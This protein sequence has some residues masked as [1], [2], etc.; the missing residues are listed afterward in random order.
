M[1]LNTFL[2]QVRIP[3]KNTKVHKT[4]CSFTFDTAE[5]NDGL[6]LDLKNY[7]S[8]NKEYALLNYKKNGQRVYLHM[9]KI[10][11]PKQSMEVDKDTA[12]PPKK[13]P[14][15]LGI[16]VPG[17]FETEGKVEYDVQETNTIV[18]LPE[19]HTLPLDDPNVPMKIQEAVAAA[20]TA[21]APATVEA[22]LQ[23][24]EKPKPS[25]YAKD[26]L[27]LNNGI[28]TPPSGWKCAKCDLT[29]N[30][31]LNLTD[32]AI[33][34][35]RYN[36]GSGKPGNGHA[37]E[38]YKENGYPL[39]VKLGTITPDGN[40]DVYSYAPDEDD[41]V[42]DPQLAQHLKHFGINISTLEKT[43]K[44]TGE[45]NLDL[46]MNYEWSRLQENDKELT[47]LFGPGYTG[48]ENIG[49]S[50]YL[51]SVMQSLFT[52]PE[53]AQR[54]FDASRAI[55]ERSSGDPNADFYVQMAKLADG[56]LSGRYAVPS[57]DEKDER[58]NPIQDGI[59][60]RS[61]KSLIGKGHA[62][63]S[64]ARQQDAL[65]YL[66]YLLQLI[67]REEKKKGEKDSLPSIFTLEFEERVQCSQS[68]AV[69]YTNRKDN[70]LSLPIPTEKASNMEEVK[71][72]KEKLE[73]LSDDEK[74][75]E[76]VVRAKVSFSDCL[77]S[78]TETETV[79]DFYSSAINAKTTA[80][81]TTKISKF[82]KYLIV[83]MRRFYVDTDWSVKKLDTLVDVPETID[84]EPYRAHGPQ[85]NE[86]L[87][88]ESS[89]DAPAAPA[90]QA[91]ESIVAQL[92]SLGFQKNSI[93]RAV[94]HT[95]NAGVEQATDWLI[96]HMEDMDF[97]EPLVISAPQKNQ[98]P[99]MDEEKV[100]ML[101]SMGFD[102]GQS[103]KALTATDNN[104]ERATEWIFSHMDDMNE[105][106][107]AAV[108]DEGRVEDGPAKY[109]LVSI[110]S[111]MGTSTASGHYVAHIKK[112]G[113]WALF[114]D[115]KV[116]ESADP[117]RDMGYIYLFQRQ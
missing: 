66:Q 10:K 5:S 87:L 23:W 95:K 100:A 74:R 108:Q 13:K 114:N 44:T 48:M 106:P 109:Q 28:K 2:D 34:C 90:F 35:G 53:F 112:K 31:W 72:F 101:M 107:A 80:F 73:K 6:Y 71:Q 39:A 110:I 40:G 22:A 111:H 30:L 8:F 67:E 59:A 12:E 24:E 104:I 62:E 14:T 102:R 82:P 68:N 29:E 94:Y 76:P 55:F 98:G 56:L 96:S 84:L 15:V 69:R 97:N 113:R 79:D 52:V 86:Q 47:R 18:I 64:T 63:F 25:K 46:N 75:K 57:S 21:E 37:L 38:H 42:E 54:Y 16:G 33:N 83:Q 11:T 78:L 27:Q 1:E 51:A 93:D 36:Y 61:F 92:L 105:A 4:E 81:K 9:K 45:M 88:P 103:V 65:E 58:H 91:D 60:P 50:C 116:G 32:G 26:L 99:I 19:F 49:N 20:L 7:Y 115:N 3:D 85:A 43:E 41:A 117:P 70:V 89:S 17:G 77:S